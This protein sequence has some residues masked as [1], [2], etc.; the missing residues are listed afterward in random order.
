MLRAGII[1]VGDELLEGRVIDRH[2]AA[3][4]EKMAQLGIPVRF[5]L[6]VG[7]APGALSQVLEDL[8]VAVDHLLIAGG[9]GPTED[10]RTRKEVAAALGLELEH[11][12]DAWQRIVAYFRQR[13]IE[14]TAGNRRQALFPAGSR[15]LP[16]ACGTA[17]GMFIER[18]TGG[19]WLL[20]GVPS[21]FRWMLDRYLTP[22]LDGGR[23]DAA[24]R[25]IL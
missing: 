18:S 6:T 22:A 16:N 2:S 3:F 23:I 15:E 19:W 8:P 9:L 20:P 17:P 4:S 12:E 13:G 10:D 21:E 7:D 11:R 25:E 14:A 24:E 1:T 5:H